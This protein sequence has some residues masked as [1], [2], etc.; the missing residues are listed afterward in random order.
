MVGAVL[1]NVYA[2]VSD[3]LALKDRGFLFYHPFMAGGIAGAGQSLLAT[4]LENVQRVIPP[5]ELVERRGEGMIRVTYGAVR[6]ALVQSSAGSVD[7]MDKWKRRLRFLYGGL[8]YVAF[9]DSIGFSIFFGVFEGVR[10]IGKGIVAEMWGLKDASELEKQNSLWGKVKV[11]AGVG[12]HDMHE[13]HREADVPELADLSTL[14]SLPSLTS[15]SSATATTSSDPSSSKPHRPLSLTMANAAA[16]IL[17]G[18]TAGMAFQL[19]IYPFEQMHPVVAAHRATMAAKAAGATAGEV[20]IAAAKAAA[21]AAAEVA[22]KGAFEASVVGATI[23]GPAGAVATEAAST[24]AASISAS[25]STSTST[26]TSANTTTTS[27]TASKTIP[28]SSSSSP[29]P[30]SSTTTSHRIPRPTLREILTIIRAQG[31]RPFYAGITS[32]L[33]RAM[34]P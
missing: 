9:K 10:H 28:L 34:P 20:E 23:E 31:I 15:S 12:P 18:G 30:S 8:G 5:L 6:R 32:Q 2:K 3:N 11:I 25:A 16:V 19:F 14:G 29:S 27:T 13:R 22:S 17:A 4:P 33:V 1:F 26:S 21:E 7:W 24:T